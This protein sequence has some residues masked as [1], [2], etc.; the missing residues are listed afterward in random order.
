MTLVPFRVLARADDI[1]AGPD[2]LTLLRRTR[3]G[4][5]ARAWQ[6]QPSKLHVLKDIED[7]AIYIQAFRDPYCYHPATRTAWSI[8]IYQ[9]QSLSKSFLFPSDGSC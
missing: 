6:A 8:V 1:F 7:L 9:H 3:S 5:A 4:Q 2:N